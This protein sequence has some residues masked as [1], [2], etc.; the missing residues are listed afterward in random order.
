MSKME[1]KLLKLLDSR[2]HVWGF[3]TENIPEQSLVNECLTKAW[4][5]TP[6]KN[7][8][9]PYHVNVI[10]PGPENQI[11]KDK[12][13]GLSKLNKRRTNIRHNV[14]NI[15]N[16]DEDGSNPNFLFYNTAPYVLIFS[17]RAA[18]PNPFIEQTIVHLNDIY[19]QMHED[20]FDDIAGTT[21]IEIGM[22]MQNATAFLLE[23][24]IDTTYIKCYPFEYSLWK[25][26]FPFLGGPVMLIAGLGYSKSSRREGMNEKQSKMDYKPEPEEIIKYI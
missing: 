3:D 10:G 25:P 26:D 23:K 17:Q 6:S 21:C 19:E 18:K 14:N 24:G 16:Y 13:H 9:M 11:L 8:F 7:N 12:I 2:K 22:F 4:K 15:E 20:L 5:V 1:K